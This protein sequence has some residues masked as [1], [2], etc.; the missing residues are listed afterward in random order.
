ML[1]G[2]ISQSR[3]RGSRSVGTISEKR[4]RATSGSRFFDRST[5]SLVQ[6]TFTVPLPTQVYKWLP[7]NLMLQGNPMIV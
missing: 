1:D 4:V 7:A 5:E 3:V 2:L 6:A